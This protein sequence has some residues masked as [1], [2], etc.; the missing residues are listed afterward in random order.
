[1]SFGR[2]NT[3]AIAVLIHVF[4]MLRQEGFS[5]PGMTKMI[6]ERILGDTTY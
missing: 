6:D 3:I 4:A 1:M 5:P 2:I